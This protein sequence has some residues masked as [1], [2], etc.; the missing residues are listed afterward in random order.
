MASVDRAALQQRAEGREWA[1]VLLCEEAD[2]E[3]VRQT[4][5]RQILR[6]LRVSTGW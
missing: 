4:K 6:M 3:D 2:S 5:R 1:P